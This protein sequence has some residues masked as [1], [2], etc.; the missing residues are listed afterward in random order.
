MAC[1][2]QGSLLDRRGQKS[3]AITFLRRALERDPGNSGLHH[4]LGVVLGSVG[5]STLAE[6]SLL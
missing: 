6:I 1:F 5:E 3:E 4:Y 2:V